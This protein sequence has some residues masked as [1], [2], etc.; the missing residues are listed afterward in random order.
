MKIIR[1]TLEYLRDCSSLT[2]GI[3]LYP[4]KQQ[5]ELPAKELIYL[6]FIAEKSSS[7]SNFRKQVPDSFSVYLLPGNAP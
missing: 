4:V 3:L 6:C 5:Q 2:Q 1:G 7:L